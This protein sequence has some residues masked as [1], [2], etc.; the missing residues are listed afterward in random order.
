[1]K[2]GP[3][4]TYATLTKTHLPELNRKPWFITLSNKSLEQIRSNVQ[5]LD[6]VGKEM[7]LV[8]GKKTIKVTQFREKLYWTF[9]VSSEKG[10]VHINLNEEGWMQFLQLLKSFN[11]ETTPMSEKNCTTCHNQMN[12]EAVQRSNSTRWT[13]PWATSIH[14]TAQC[15]RGQ[16]T[17]SSVRILWC[18]NQLGLPLPPR[19]LPSMLTR[20]LL[21]RMWLMRLLLL[22]I[23]K[24]TFIIDSILLYDILTSTYMAM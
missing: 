21:L 7:E 2:E 14:Y 17:R 16:P 15:N 18:S 19:Q 3:Y 6:A 20:V 1:M 8:T 5:H 23:L 22:W 9:S 11:Q 12:F 4:G 13:I 24:R 10:I